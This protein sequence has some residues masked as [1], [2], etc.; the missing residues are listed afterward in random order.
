MRAGAYAVVLCDGECSF[1]GLCAAPARFGGASGHAGLAAENPVLFAGEI[2]IE[3]SGRLIAWNS[4]SGTYEMPN[5]YISQSGLPLSLYWKFVAAEDV[6]DLPLGSTLHRLRQGDALMSPGGLVSGAQECTGHDR[7]SEHAHASETDS[8][9]AVGGWQGIPA[10]ASGLATGSSLRAHSAPCTP[11]TSPA[12]CRSAPRAAS[13]ADFAQMLS[14]DTQCDEDLGADFSPERSVS[15]SASP[16]SCRS[17]HRAASSADFTQSSSRAHSA[18]CTPPTSPAQCRSAHRAT[19]S[20]DFTQMLHT[21][22]L[23]DDD[24][25]ADYSPTPPA[26][27]S[28]PCRSTSPA[29]RCSSSRSA[30][31]APRRSASPSAPPPI[32]AVATA[33]VVTDFAESVVLPTEAPQAQKA[34][35]RKRIK[36]IDCKEVSAR[37]F[38]RQ[39]TAVAL[40]F[41]E[42]ATAGASTQAAASSRP[43]PQGTGPAGTVA[44]PASNPAGHCPEASGSSAPTLQDI[45]PAELDSMIRGAFAGQ[46]LAF[47]CGVPLAFVLRLPGIVYTIKEQGGLISQT[48]GKGDGPTAPPSAAERPKEP[49]S[50]KSAGA[51]GTRCPEKYFAPGRVRQAKFLRTFYKCKTPEVWDKVFG[52]HVLEDRARTAALE[53]NIV[54]LS[55][56]NR[57]VLEK[58]MLRHGWFCKA[59]VVNHPL[60]QDCCRLTRA[61]PDIEFSLVRY[62][63]TMSDLPL[64]LLLVPTGGGDVD[65]PW[66][67]FWTHHCS[68]KLVFGR[69]RES[70]ADEAAKYEA[71]R[72]DIIVD[73]FGE[74]PWDIS[75][76]VARSQFLLSR[77]TRIEAPLNVVRI[78]DG[79]SEDS[80][81]KRTIITEGCGRICFHYLRGKLG[82]NV[83]AVQAR[84][85]GAKGVWTGC[86]DVERDSMEVRTSQVKLDHLSIDHLEV[87]T[88]FGP[89]TAVPAMLSIELAI[90]FQDLVRAED[91]GRL[92]Q[93]LRDALEDHIRKQVRDVFD[94]DVVEAQNPEPRQDSWHSIS[95]ALSFTEQIPKATWNGHGPFEM[96]RRVQGILQHL[97]SMEQTIQ[98]PLP[99]AI[100][101]PGQAGE[102]LGDTEVFVWNPKTSDWIT[103]R[104][105]VARYPL[106]RSADIR[107]CIAVVPVKN[108]SSW[109]Y[110]ISFGGPQPGGGDLDGD[111]YLV[112]FGALAACL[113]VR[114]PPIPL[115]DVEKGIPRDTTAMVTAAEVIEDVNHLHRYF[116]RFNA[117]LVGRVTMAF[118]EASVTA[119]QRDYGFSD[120]RIESL[121]AYSSIVMDAGKRNHRSTFYTEYLDEMSTG[122]RRAQKRRL[123]AWFRNNREGEFS[124]ET[125]QDLL[126]EELL[127]PSDIQQFFV[128]PLLKRVVELGAYSK[129]KLVKEIGGVENPLVGLR[130]TP[131]SLRNPPESALHLLELIAKIDREYRVQR[132]SKEETACAFRRIHDRNPFLREQM[133]KLADV[134][135]EEADFVQYV[136]FWLS[137]WCGDRGVGRKHTAGPQKPF[138]LPA[139]YTTNHFSKLMTY[140]LCCAIVNREDSDDTVGEALGFR[141]PSRR[142][143]PPAKRRRMCEKYATVDWYV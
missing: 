12:P 123:P 78:A 83:V 75:K 63:S 96:S 90:A 37:E 41:L 130:P 106:T 94:A 55:L 48:G 3:E 134:P 27:S 132:W 85:G 65:R 66:R 7:A 68:G 136:Y 99:D 128:A 92:D 6:A 120:E 53:A 36:M 1:R 54:K 127:A 82:R 117:S 100:M 140:D 8:A 73:H 133:K 21:D 45:D 108:V 111:R 62:F 42:A 72:R 81:G 113:Q 9:A 60:K 44:S 95:E 141:P 11:P 104:V 4:I 131:F 47:R 14:A 137:K 22:G 84:A 24:L 51:V 91:R 121:G 114:P 33:G 20:A 28:S 80:N 31:P 25:G 67:F 139:G 79:F 39:A 58:Q 70:V 50:S 18:P 86:E 19:S 49:V 52:N 105:L 102:G 59:F 23:C 112:F 129:D 61:A 93:L 142:G 110:M 87:V 43:P 109:L 2:Q 71:R 56:K 13:S 125:L 103:G 118:F 57:G 97:H 10:P 77:T 30:L 115:D 34:A 76:M 46:E 38:M 69:L 122:D 32:T 138:R 29:P 26:Q 116:R 40:P 5:R 89:A 143:D 16:A 15:R 35:S 107:E 74:E 64:P 101:L 88:A 126:V 119:V 98:M 124:N 135:Q 17:A